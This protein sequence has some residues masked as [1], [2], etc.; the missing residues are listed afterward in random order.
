[1]TDP[2][3]FDPYLGW[4]D[5]TDPNNIPADARAIT[6]GDLLRYEQLGINVVARV[7]EH[8]VR[9][10][11]HEVRLDDLALSSFDPATIIEI[12]GGGA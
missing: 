7:N 2:I 4:V 5:I 8:E 1:M 10:D 11:D 3:S 9:L 12:D 6:A